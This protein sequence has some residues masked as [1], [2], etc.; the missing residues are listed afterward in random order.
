M[1]VLRFSRGGGVFGLVAHPP[2]NPFTNMSLVGNGRQRPFQSGLHPH[3]LCPRGESGNAHVGRGVCPSGG[4]AA[5][6]SQPGIQACFLF[7]CTL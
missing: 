5:A 1:A 7:Y 3:A 2:F 6:E 4:L